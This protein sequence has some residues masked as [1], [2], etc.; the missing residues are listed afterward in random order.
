MCQLC[1]LAGCAPWQV[2]LCG[3]LRFWRGGE[4]SAALSFL[5]SL[6]VCRARIKVMCGQLSA[7]MG[8]MVTGFIANLCNLSC[9]PG[10]QNRSASVRA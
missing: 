6:A 1:V 5:V 3:R 7:K 9:N 8:E 10:L 2:Q 4:G